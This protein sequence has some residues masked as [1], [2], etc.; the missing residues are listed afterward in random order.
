M[1]G[2]KEEACRF[3]VRAD[4]RGLKRDEERERER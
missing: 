3:G 4:G 2:K 1:V